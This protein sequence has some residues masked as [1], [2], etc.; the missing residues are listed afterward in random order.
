MKAPKL[1][2]LALL[3]ASALPAQ[4][5]T[6]ADNAKELQALKER[7]AELEKKVAEAA[8]RGAPA[9]DGAEVARIAVK[10]EALEDSRDAAGLKGLKVSGYVDPVYLYNFNQKRAGFQFL[11]PIGT[12]PYATYASYFA[13]AALDLQKEMESGV[14]WRLTLIPARSTGEV[15]GGAGIVHEA[16]VS[17]PLTSATTRLIAGQLPDWSGYEYLPPTQNKLIT[18]NLL[19][20]LTLPVAYTGAGLELTR[21]RWVIK[22]VIANL[23]T[24]MRSLGEYVPMLMYRG[25]YTGGEYWGFGFAGVH[26]KKTNLRAADATNPVTTEPYSTRDTWADLFEIDGWYTRGDLTLNAHLGA[27]HQK[28]AAI[29]A[30]P[31]TGNLREALW[32]GASVLAAY[33]F[34]PRFEGIVRADYIYNRKNGGGLLDYVT[35]DAFNGIGPDPDPAADPEKGTDRYAVTAGIGYAMN[36]NTTFKLEY[37]FDGTTLPVFVKDNGFYAKSNHQVATSV[38]VSF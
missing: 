7:I 5:Q 23:N 3:L 16:S 21:G 6:A 11:V 34:T 37:R 22:A 20:D 13:T 33:K 32:A 35:A 10:T 19:F 8:K 36:A 2:T 12:Q 25:D 26:G 29:T 28:D 27:G 18:H 31:V 14:R 9:A 17:I 38:V 15:M 24:P 1:T 30:D 4:A